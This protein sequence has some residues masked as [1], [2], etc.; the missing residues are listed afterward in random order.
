MW[1][2]GTSLV[3]LGGSEYQCFKHWLHKRWFNLFS[4]QEG[5]QDLGG[6]SF[7]TAPAVQTCSGIQAFNASPSSSFT[8]VSPSCPFKKKK[9]G[10]SSRIHPISSMNQV[11]NPVKTRAVQTWGDYSPSA[12]T[13][14][15]CASDSSSHTRALKLTNNPRLTLSWM[16]PV[17][18]S[19]R[20]DFMS[21]RGDEK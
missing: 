7:F 21:W 20:L 6:S 16:L 2:W 12:T 3:W 13:Y 11:I 1:S 9:K 17:I 18:W 5:G 8:P 10:V 4:A 15:P 14:V 19:V